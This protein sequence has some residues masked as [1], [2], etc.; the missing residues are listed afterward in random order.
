M[1]NNFSI[2]KLSIFWACILVSSQL[3]SQKRYTIG[4]LYEWAIENAAITRGMALTEQNSDLQTRIASVANYPQISINGQSTYQS[5]VTSLPIKIPNINVQE[6]SKDQYKL[7]LDVQQLIYN[8]GIVTLQKKIV[9]SNADSEKQQ[10]LVEQAKLR[11]R[12]LQ[13]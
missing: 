8:G 1:S 6:T 5:D 13:K 9:R 7:V 10:T 2:I 4:Q 11:D 3:Y 12:I